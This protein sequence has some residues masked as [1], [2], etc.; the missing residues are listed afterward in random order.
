MTEHKPSAESPRFYSRPSDRS[1]EAYK[2]WFRGLV[3]HLGLKGDDVTDEQLENNCREFWAAAD[4]AQASKSDNDS[5]NSTPSSTFKWSKPEMD[6]LD[7]ELV[8]LGF[9]LMPG[10]AQFIAIM[11]WDK[12]D[13][14]KP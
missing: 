3:H 2:R 9:E 13:E 10:D 1:L 8:E 4:K 12:P 7:R 14:E 5:H 6:E 11:G